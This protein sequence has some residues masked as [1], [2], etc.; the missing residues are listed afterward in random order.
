MLHH[1]RCPVVAVYERM[2]AGDSKSISGGEVGC[3]ESATGGEVSRARDC[4]FEASG[5]PHARGSPPYLAICSSWASA[6]IQTHST[7]TIRLFGK[8]AERSPAARHHFACLGH[9]RVEVHRQSPQLDSES[10]LVTDRVCPIATSRCASRSLGRP[11]PAELPM[12]VYP[13]AVMEIEATPLF[14]SSVTGRQL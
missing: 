3:V 7:A 11:T 6:S 14:S 4:A 10:V 5:I 9:L 13:E 8:F 12:S 2:V 1:C